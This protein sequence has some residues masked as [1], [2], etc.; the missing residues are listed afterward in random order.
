[1]SGLSSLFVLLREYISDQS[2]ESDQ[3]DMMTIRPGR[4]PIE[5]RHMLGIETIHIF[6]KSG[7]RKTPCRVVY[8]GV[9]RVTC[10]L[11]Y[12]VP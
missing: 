5:V 11:R 2:D 4:L 8:K 9:S 7:E 12:F 1:M 10:G 3:S 6:V